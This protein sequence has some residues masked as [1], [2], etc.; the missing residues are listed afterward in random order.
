MNYHNSLA[1]ITFLINC[2]VRKNNLQI[3]CLKLIL[4]MFIC[5]IAFSPLPKIPVGKNL[6]NVIFYRTSQRK[7]DNHPSVKNNSV[8]KRQQIKY[9]VRVM[10]NLF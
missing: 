4:F 7:S 9:E 1:E 10:I 3:K 6:L 2:A 5:A 8:Y